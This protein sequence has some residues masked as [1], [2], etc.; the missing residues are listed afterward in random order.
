MEDGDRD[1]D[2]WRDD[3]AQTYLCGAGAAVNAGADLS[4]ARICASLVSGIGPAVAEHSEV[5]APC[6]LRG[7][8]AS[9]DVWLRDLLDAPTAL[10]ACCGFDLCHQYILYLFVFAHHHACLVCLCIFVLEACAVACYVLVWGCRVLCIVLLLL[11][12][13]LL[14]VCMFAVI[15]N[16]GPAPHAPRR[17]SSCVC[18]SPCGRTS[19]GAATPPCAARRSGSCSSCA[20][21]RRSWCRRSSRCG[22][23]AGQCWAMHQVRVRVRRARDIRAR[24]LRVRVSVYFVS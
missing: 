9:C 4:L 16:F 8:D 12:L 23:R 10:A 6:V 11:L 20:C 17:R 22:S 18:C 1:V 19:A 3:A 15:D 13:L 5:R 14:Y 2:G 21:S 7:S 24:S